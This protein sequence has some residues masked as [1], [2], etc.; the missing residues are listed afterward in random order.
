M[1]FEYC[2]FDFHGVLTAMIQQ[3][4]HVVEGEDAKGRQTG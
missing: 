4:V 1:K 2:V 3:F